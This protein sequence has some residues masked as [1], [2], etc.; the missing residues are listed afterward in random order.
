MPTVAKDKRLRKFYYLSLLGLFP[1]FGILIGIVLLCYAI[2]VFRNLKL[3]FTILLAMGGGIL[4]MK[5]D[6]YYLSQDLKY[7]KEHDNDFSLL[8]A[9]DLDKIVQHLDLYKLQHGVYPDSLQQLEKQDP[10]LN[11]MDP[12]L[13]RN[14][15]AHK[16]IN[17]Y[18]QRKGDSYTLFS[19][20]IDGIPHTKD[21]IY[22]RKPIK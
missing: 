6:A 19:S 7:G 9:D 16:F 21:D 4:L 2:F 10:T 5:L 13:G 1:G 14:S 3:I 18:Y 12:L 22:P 15:A 17:Y 11:I 20:G 8:A